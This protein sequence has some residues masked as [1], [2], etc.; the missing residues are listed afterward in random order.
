MNQV[1]QVDV[2]L[3]STIT[4]SS[5]DTTSSECVPD[6]CKPQHVADAGINRTESDTSKWQSAL[7]PACAPVWIKADWG[8]QIP[9]SISSFSIEY[10]MPSYAT[11]SNL[12]LTS[13]AAGL[14]QS[15]QAYTC[16]TT[17]VNDEGT[18]GRVDTCV[19]DTT[20]QGGLIWDTVA[21]KFTFSFGDKK[22]LGCQVAVDEI[23]I[24]GLPSSDPSAVGNAKPS[25]S[26]S[27]ISVGG[28]VGI[29]FALVGVVGVVGLYMTRQRNLRL[30]KLATKLYE[31]RQLRGNGAANGT[32]QLHQ[33]EDEGLVPVDDPW[34]DR[35]NSVS[36]R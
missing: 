24:L 27:V 36:A 13:T 1:G 32:Y 4:A 12:Q 7:D 35:N 3:V 16:S 34:V 11:L 26:S 5:T 9:Y 23:L 33:D 18:T 25:K 22:E 21:A 14:L 20:Q 17:Y 8:D 10:A 29:V 15:L 19:F 28:I 6:K 30:R 31:E 2:T